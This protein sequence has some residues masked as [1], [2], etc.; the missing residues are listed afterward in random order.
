MSEIHHLSPSPDRPGKNDSVRDQSDWGHSRIFRYF[1]EFLF[2]GTRGFV[3]ELSLALIALSFLYAHGGSF[4]T[5]AMK[6]GGF[7]QEEV[8]SWFELH[9]KITLRLLSDTVLTSLFRGVALA[10]VAHFVGGIF[11]L[12]VFFLGAFIGLVPVVGSAMVLVALVFARLVERGACQG[13]GDGCFV[14]VF[15]LLDKPGSSQNGPQASRA[16]C[17]A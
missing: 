7:N 15:E 1:L 12:P 14:P 11:F 16:G 8:R 6:M 17:L 10:L 3:A 2:K 5:K 13:L 9:R 4:L